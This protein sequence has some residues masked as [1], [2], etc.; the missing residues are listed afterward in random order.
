VQREERF[1][2]DPNYKSPKPPGTREED[3]W[4][5]DEQLARCAPRRRNLS[6]PGPDADGLQTANT[7]RSRRRRNRSMS[8]NESRSSLRKSARRWA[9]AGASFLG[10]SGGMAASLIA[11]KRRSRPEV[12]QG[13]RRG[14][15]RARSCKENGPPNDLFVFDDRRTSCAARRSRAVASARSHRARAGRLPT[16]ISYPVGTR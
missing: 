1:L 14:D 10:G 12:L 2:S 8:S 7:C 3:S 16:R 15:V 6:S 4:L 11:M 5:S 9:L 13:R